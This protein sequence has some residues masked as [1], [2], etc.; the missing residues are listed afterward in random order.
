[1]FAVTFNNA[2]YDIG[3]YD[4]IGDTIDY[5]GPD[6]DKVIEAALNSDP[7]YPMEYI[8]NSD[9]DDSETVGYFYEADSDHEY[10]TAVLYV[11]SS[12]APE[13]VK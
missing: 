2:Y 6:K 10:P 8:P 12:N 11:M 3:G 1:M 13:F 5:Y 4:D 9:N 7:D